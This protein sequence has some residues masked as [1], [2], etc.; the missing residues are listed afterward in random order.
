MDDGGELPG[1]GGDRAGA[2][3]TADVATSRTPPPATPTQ[4]SPAFRNN[5][6]SAIDLI[7]W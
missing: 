2:G 1:V 6:T 4:P 3:N 7:R 5:F